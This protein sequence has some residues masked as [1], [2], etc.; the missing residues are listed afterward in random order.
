MPEQLKQGLLQIRSALVTGNSYTLS[1]FTESFQKHIYTNLPPHK[2]A[3]KLT[4]ALKEH[5][6]QQLSFDTRVFL[7]LRV[8]QVPW[9]FSSG[10]PL[11]DV[12][13]TT[14]LKAIPCHARLAIFRWLIDSEPDL[15]FRLRPFL[16]RSSLC[17]CGCGQLS[18]IY[19][20]GLSRGAIHSSHLHFDLLYTLAFSSLPDDSLSPQPHVM[21]PPLP[22][23][24]S[25][26][27][28]PSAPVKL[29]TPLLCSLPPYPIGAHFLVSFVAPAITPFN[30]GSSSVLFW[31]LLVASFLNNHGKPG[32]GFSLRKLHSSVVLLLVDYGS[33]LG[34]SF[35]RDLAFPPPHWLLPL[36]LLLH[37]LNFPNCSL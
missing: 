21:H 18:S 29:P 27:N 11:L 17:I 4:S 34:N 7:R 32:F 16:S 10:S 19:P 31:H 36:L 20:F 23:L 35:M 12:L 30:I 33:P 6:L 2:L 8:S 14:P 13:H 1:S 25:P 5:L 28:G 24:L 15:H 3:K 22:R 37:S 9:L 26:L